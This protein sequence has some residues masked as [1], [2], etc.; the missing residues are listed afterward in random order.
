M[1][2]FFRVC[3]CEIELLS[4]A[5]W[6]YLPTSV[7]SCYTTTST[8]VIHICMF[9]VKCLN[10]SKPPLYHIC[11]C[12]E[13]FIV[14]PGGQST[15]QKFVWKW[16]NGSNSTRHSKFHTKFLKISSAILTL[17]ASLKNELNTC[18]IGLSTSLIF[19]RTRKLFAWYLN[20]TSINF[21]VLN[22]SHFNNCKRSIF[23]LFH[24]MPSKMFNTQRGKL[25]F[26]TIV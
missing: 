10:S 14:N 4:S 12:V 2:P 5:Q 26:R 15:S 7:G 20:M 24:E 16:Q 6:K 23:F 1:A 9:R 25:E 18:R 21:E 13:E 17:S 11:V 19:P 8:N 3:V 22:V